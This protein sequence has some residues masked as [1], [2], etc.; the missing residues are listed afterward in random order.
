MKYIKQLFIFFALFCLGFKSF[1]Q[2]TKQLCKKNGE[3]VF[4]FQ[5]N[6]K[7]WVSISK[8]KNEQYIVYR[9]GTSAKVELRYPDNLDSTSWQQFTFK[10]YSR[11][12]GIQNAAMSYAILHFIHNDTEYDIYETW[13]SEDN[14]EHCGIIITLNKKDIDMAG[15]LKTR[16]GDLLSL[17]YGTKIKMEEDN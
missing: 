11:G 1:S 17:S 12:G 15:L 14:E 10:G 16:K 2:L 8:E 5:L 4:A 9:F 3:I 13:N 7:K 6:N